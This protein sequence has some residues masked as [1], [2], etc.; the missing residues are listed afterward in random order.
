[1]DSKLNEETRQLRDMGLKAANTLSDV[2]NKVNEIKSTLTPEQRAEVE[3][4]EKQAGTMD[5]AL[6]NL[7][8]I[9]FKKWA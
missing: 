5:E 9:D 7:Q 2:I 4:A 3:E 6:K 8:N 1:M